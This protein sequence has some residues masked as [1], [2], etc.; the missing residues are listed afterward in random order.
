MD[1]KE[2]VHMGYGAIVTGAIAYVFARLS[3]RKDND[4]QRWREMESRVSALE[5]ANRDIIHIKAKQEEIGNDLK[6]VI[7]TLTELRIYLGKSPS[8][9]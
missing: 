5:L 6:M 4:E 9:H 2:I 8:S 3:S 7:E 1:E